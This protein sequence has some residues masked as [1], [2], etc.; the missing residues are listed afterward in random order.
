M[1]GLLQAMPG[2]KLYQRLDR[3]GRLLGHTTGDNVDGTTNFIPRMNRERL[4]PGLP[5]LMEYLYSPGPYYRRIRTFLREYR[6]PRISR[7]LNWRCI[8]WPSF[9]PAS[10]WVSWVANASITGACSC[11]RSPPPLPLFPGRHA[12]HLRPPLPQSQPSA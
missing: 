6:P 9:M 10:G 2:T 5:G 4:A 7:S 1:V 12:L 11:G 8:S 3:Q